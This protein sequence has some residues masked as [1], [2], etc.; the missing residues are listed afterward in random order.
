MFFRPNNNIIAPHADKVSQLIDWAK[1]IWKD[2]DCDWEFILYILQ[3]KIRRV[4]FN[5]TKLN[6]SENVEAVTKEIKDCEDAIERILDH[7][8]C[9]EEFDSINDEIEK[10]FKEDCGNLITKMSEWP[11]GLEERFDNL[12]KKRKNS[13]SKDLEFLFSCMKHM[14]QWFV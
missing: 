8:Y 14:R 3:H 11:E 5:I 9:K 2:E 4:R 1:V 13:E 12:Y 10:Q 6:R 7:N